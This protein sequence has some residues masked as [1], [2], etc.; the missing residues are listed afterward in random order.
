VS[1]SK[2]FWCSV[3]FYASEDDRNYSEFFIYDSLGGGLNSSSSPVAFGVNYTL[4]FS[5]L[6]SNS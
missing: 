1:S 5:D 6:R 3:G 2:S 4:F